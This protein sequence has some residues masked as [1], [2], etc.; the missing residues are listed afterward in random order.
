[1]RFLAKLAMRSAAWVLVPAAVLAVPIQ[2]TPNPLGDWIAPSLVTADVSLLSGDTQ[3][4]PAVVL[5]S[6]VDGN[7]GAYIEET[8]Y[9]KL[10]EIGLYYTL[11]ETFLGSAFKRLRLG[12]S[13]NNVLLWTSYGSYDP[14]V[15]NF[16]TQPISGNIEVTPYPSSR[17]LFFHIKADF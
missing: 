3:P 5:R 7:T 4:V 2:M 8:S 1:M 10:R 12:V 17:R 11:P 16:G 13:A 15:S 9:V 14:E 6:R